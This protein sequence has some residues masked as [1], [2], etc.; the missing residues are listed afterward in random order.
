VPFT[1]VWDAVA[2]HFF[3]QPSLE[4]VAKL[5]TEE[6]QEEGWFKRELIK[7]FGELQRV[8]LINSW[9]PEVWMGPARRKIDFQVD[10]GGAIGAV[11]VKTALCGSQKGYVWK[12]P[13]YVQ[14][15]RNGFIMTDVDKL[16]G[17]DAL[18]R[19][20]VVF[21]H[22]APPR[23]DWDKVLM[24]VRRKA[25]ALSVDLPRVNDSPGGVLS[26]GWLRVAR[27]KA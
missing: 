20:L 22:A 24:D 1:P 23:V 2:A 13:G 9:Q 3:S 19:V 21:A 12:L 16:G 7:L 11:E 27:T 26:I 15:V 5:T 6:R 25:P 14:T 4:Y 18:H 10:L 17:I 8:G